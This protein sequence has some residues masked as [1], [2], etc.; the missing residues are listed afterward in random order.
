MNAK[1][2]YPIGRVLIS[3]LILISIVRSPEDYEYEKDQD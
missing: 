3:I 2:R 1:A